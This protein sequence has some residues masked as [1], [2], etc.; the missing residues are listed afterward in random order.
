MSVHLGG[1]D[2]KNH[3]QQDSSLN[4]CKTVLFL[5]VSVQ[6]DTNDDDFYIVSECIYSKMSCTFT[7]LERTQLRLPED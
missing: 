2:M 6:S 4:L 7:S 1:A 5:D 3:P